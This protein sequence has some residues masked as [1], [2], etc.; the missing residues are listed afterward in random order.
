[1]RV[2]VCLD[3][4]PVG[5]R[6]IEGQPKGY[7]IDVVTQLAE[8]LQVQL[9]LVEV[10]VPARFEAL[11][12]GRV[13]ILACNV[14]ATTDRALEF[15]FSFPYLR[16]GIKLL[17]LRDSGIDGLDDLDGDDMVAV[18]RGT[19]ADALLQRRAPL[20]ERIFVSSS[21]EASLLLRQGQVDAYLQDSLI[22][23]YIARSLPDKVQALPEVYSFDAICFAI[24]K[25]NPELLRWLDLF[26]SLYVSSGAYQRT[27]ANWWGETP[28]PLTPIW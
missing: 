15:D 26:A 2:G 13:D 9:T 8:Q 5:F 17:A 24:R 23:D 7:D 27:Y 11:R 21:G 28:P 3:S 14:S 6:D 22:V 18:G 12:A 1:V 10:N 4:E 25:G 16:T 19:T 20:A